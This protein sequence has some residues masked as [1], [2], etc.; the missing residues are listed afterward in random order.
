MM[1]A[2]PLLESQVITY[3]PVSAVLLSECTLH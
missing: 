2:V 3:V 1:S